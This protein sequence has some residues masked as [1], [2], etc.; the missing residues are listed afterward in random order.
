[1]QKLIEDQQRRTGPGPGPGP[2]HLGINNGSGPSAV[3]I[4]GMDMRR[5]AP[6][7]HEHPA[8]MVPK[9]QGTAVWQ[10]TLSW[11]GHG[12]AGKKEMIIYVVASTTS[13]QPK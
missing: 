9:T 8:G 12:P 3:P 7:A 10:G 6:Q 1:M 13:P 5:Q 11:S 4:G 2:G